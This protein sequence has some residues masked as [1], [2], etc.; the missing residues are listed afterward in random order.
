MTKEEIINELDKLENRIVSFTKKIADIIGDSDAI[1]DPKIKQCINNSN[2]NVRITTT[3]RDN[4]FNNYCYNYIIEFYEEYQKYQ[5]NSDDYKIYFSITLNREDRIQIDSNFNLI[6]LTAESERTLK[7][8]KKFNY[9]YKVYLGFG[10][11]HFNQIWIE[12]SKQNPKYSKRFNLKDIPD[13]IFDKD[14]FIKFFNNNINEKLENLKKNLKENIIDIP[15]SNCIK[16]FVIV[17]KNFLKGKSNLYKDMDDLGVLDLDTS[18]TLEK[19]NEIG[20]LDDE[21]FFILKGKLEKYYDNNYIL[22]P[23]EQYDK[24]VKD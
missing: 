11:S 21:K 2:Y 16:Q 19:L 1:Y 22:I 10:K 20:Q 4:L 24:I 17:S 5:F 9:D 14:V 6:Y 23:R 7:I 12:T 18:M 15:D 3:G 13:N 8:A